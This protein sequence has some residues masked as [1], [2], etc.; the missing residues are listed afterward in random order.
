[1]GCSDCAGPLVVDG[2]VVA[3][4]RGVVCR[5]DCS[6]SVAAADEAVGCVASWTTRVSPGWPTALPTWGGSNA[7]RESVSRTRDAGPSTAGPAPRETTVVATTPADT[8]PPRATS[9]RRSRGSSIS[10]TEVTRRLRSPI[11][12]WARPPDAEHAQ[13]HQQPGSAADSQLAVGQVGGEQRFQEPGR[14][15]GGRDDDQGP[16][17]EASHRPRGV[18]QP[19]GEEHRARERH[20]GRRRDDQTAAE[21]GCDPE[22]AD[23]RNPGCDED[24][25]SAGRVIALRDV[26]VPTDP[27]ET[28]VRRGCENRRR[29]RERQEQ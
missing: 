16:H 14:E 21:Q 20:R 22:A 4:P 26:G 28:D 29:D 11:R 12:S 27:E 6:P 7:P 19:C 10:G 15:A 5:V 18:T 1:M 13:R 8:I 23:A 3:V 17:D 2:A 25:Q 24:P 9:R